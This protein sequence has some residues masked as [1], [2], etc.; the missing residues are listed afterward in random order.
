M[1]ITTCIFDLDGVIVDTAK[2]H[3]LAW[4]RLAKEQFNKD[5][6]IHDN[7]QLKGV[8][9][10]ESLNILLRICGID[11]PDNIKQILADLKNK[12]YVEYIKKI[13]PDEILPGVVKFLGQAKNHKLYLA[14]ASASKNARLLLER[15]GLT[16]MFDCIVDGTVV[17]RA[18]PDPEVFLKC[19]EELNVEPQNCVVFEDAIAGIEAA[20]AGEMYAVGVGEKHILYKADMVISSFKNIYIDDVLNLPKTKNHE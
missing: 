3:Y 16:S 14:L 2:Y 1:N 9:R 5:F 12:W 18:K 7:E 8:S 13:T 19:A 4:K 20:H 11:V 15:I 17:T 6:S 10:D